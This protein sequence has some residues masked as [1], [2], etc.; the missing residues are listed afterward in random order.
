MA[1]RLDFFCARIGVALDA[2]DGENDHRR[3]FVLR[4][5]AAEPHNAP[6]VRKLDDVAHRCRPLPVS[7][8]NP[9]PAQVGIGIK[10]HARL[11]R[12]LCGTPLTP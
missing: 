11:T 10:W 4:A 6:L 2:D 8:D 12:R 7:A 9:R 5:G 3:G 1:A